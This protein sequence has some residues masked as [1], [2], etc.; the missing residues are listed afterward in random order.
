[1]SF[2]EL[3]V[4]AGGG[5]DLV[6]LEVVEGEA[7]GVQFEDFLGGDSVDAQLEIAAGV[8]FGAGLAGFVVDDF[9][10]FFANGIDLVDA[11]VDDDVVFER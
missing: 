11:A 4:G 10:V 2:V 9:D 6:V 3:L 8:G 5:L 7:D 1:L